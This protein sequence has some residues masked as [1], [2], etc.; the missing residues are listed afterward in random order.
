MQVHE[1]PTVAAASMAIVGQSN[2]FPIRRVFCIGRNYAWPSQGAQQGEKREPP[3]FFMKPAD[4]VVPAVG[5]IPYPPLTHDF[6]HEIELIVAIGKD[7][8]NI[9]PEDALAH[10]WGYAAGLDLTRRDLQAEAKA[11]GRPWEGSKAFDASAP[12][13]PLVPVAASGHPDTGAI[14]LKVN[15]VERQRADLAD[16][17]WPV[18]NIISFLSTS[19]TLKA[20]DLIF[21][22]TPAGV[23]SLHPGD[24]LHGGI[25]GISEFTVTIGA[26]HTRHPIAHA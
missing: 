24:V 8:T 17:I 13:S 10:V 26:K 22:G 20:G 16:Q 11:Q 12:S 4:V 2:R 3:V 6:C 19:V 25:S 9:T 7:A 18:K 14:W 15:G 1:I 5:E 23:D 21:T